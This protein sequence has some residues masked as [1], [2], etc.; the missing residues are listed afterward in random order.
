MQVR[1][2]YDVIINSPAQDETRHHITM[3]LLFLSP[4]LNPLIYVGCNRGYRNYI[5]STFGRCWS[6]IKPKSLNTYSVE[7]EMSVN[8]VQR[9]KTIGEWLILIYVLRRINSLSFLWTISEQFEVVQMI[10]L[11]WKKYVRDIYRDKRYCRKWYS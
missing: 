3:V 7:L 1:V 5:V 9:G 10:W 8:A 11:M 4:L 2:L 6:K